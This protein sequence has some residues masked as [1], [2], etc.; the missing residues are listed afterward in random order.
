MAR[1]E[2]SNKSTKEFQVRAEKEH[3]ASL[4]SE[5]DQKVK[6]IEMNE[7][8]KLPKR[9][10]RKWESMDRYRRFFSRERTPEKNHKDLA[11]RSVARVSIGILKNMT[12]LIFNKP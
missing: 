3:I 11:E 9:M 5:I 12:N 8:R 6:T 2:W 4:K 10:H 1:E 7:L